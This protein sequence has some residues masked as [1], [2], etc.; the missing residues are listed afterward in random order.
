MQEADIASLSALVLWCV[1]ALA[2]VFGAIAQRTHFCTLGAVTDIINM[3][4]WTRMRVW[5]LT[6]GVAILGFNLMVGLGWLHAEKTIY[7]APRLLWLSNLVGGL[8]FGFG[9]ALASG[10][11]S[12]TLIRIGAGNLKSLLVFFVMGVSAFATLKGITA[13]ARVASVDKVGVN[14]P[15]GQDLP[16]LVSGLW[17]MSHGVWAL[18]LGGLV[19][20]ALVLWALSSREGRSGDSIL[21]GLGLGTV[22]VAS[23]WVSGRLGHVLEDPLTLQEAFLGSTGGQRM[24]S[25]TFVAPIAYTLDWLMFFSDTSKVLTIGIVSV[26]GLIVGSALQARIS[27]TFRWEG[28]RDVEDMANHFVGAVLMGIGGVTAMGCTIGQGVS[29]LSTLS[30]GSF[31]AL[32]AIIAGAVLGL[33][34]QIWRVQRLG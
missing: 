18:L 19:G 28:F 23:W 34:Y 22:I 32:G 13:V 25:F 27:G 26:F 14:M 8:L 20:A 9:M 33:R 3:G 7:A 31:I 12:K 4:D 10:C 6:M 24:E 16:S 2:L 21:A 1:F 29:G 15:L 5:V 17:G 30:L 11:A